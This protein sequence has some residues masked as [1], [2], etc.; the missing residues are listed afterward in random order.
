[1]NSPFKGKFKVT[2]EYKGSS[3]D[4]L[5][6]VGIDSK[7]IYSTIDGTVEVAGWENP[8]NKKQGF[9]LYVRIKQNNTEDRYYFGHMSKINVRIGQVV[10]AGD[11][12]GVEGSTGYSTGSHCHYCVRTNA[13]KKGIKDISVISGIP[14]KIGTYEDNDGF[15]TAPADKITV[16]YQVWDDVRNSWLP[17]V[18]DATDYAGIYDHDVCAVYADLSI[19]NITYKVHTKGYKWLPSVINKNDYA[20]IFNRP[21]DGIAMKVDKGTIHYQVHLRAENR[22]LPYVTGYNTEDN[23]NGYA[24]IIGKEIDAIRIYVD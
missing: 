1:M 21:I 5:D 4:G 19:G 3:H 13:S 11:L 23:N 9:G 22:W 8:S 12:L 2:Q 14:N 6:I 20:G 18:I 16:T 24:G 10:K 15:P 17:N 7:N